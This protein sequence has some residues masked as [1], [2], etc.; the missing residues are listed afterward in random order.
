MRGRLHA[1][2][3]QHPATRSDRNRVA[4][5]SNGSNGSKSCST[6]QIN[7]S[8]PPRS[9][10]I[11]AESP[12]ALERPRSGPH[13][14]RPTPCSTGATRHVRHQRLRTP[15]ARL[16]LERARRATACRAAVSWASPSVS[17]RFAGSISAS[18]AVN[19]SNGPASSAGSRLRRQITT[20]TPR[21]RAATSGAGSLV[22]TASTPDR[23]SATA[24][25]GVVDDPCARRT[26]R[27]DAHAP[28][29]PGPPPSTSAD[30]RQH[31]RVTLLVARTPARRRPPPRGGQQPRRDPRFEFARPG[32]RERVEAG[33]QHRARRTPP[34][35]R[36]SSVGLDHPLTIG[37][38]VGIA[39]DV[40]DLDVD[41]DPTRHA[42]SA[43]RA[44]VGTPCEAT[45]GRRV[46]RSRRTS[47][48]DS[49]RTAPCPSVV[50]S[51]SA[52]CITTG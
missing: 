6:A 48:R 37:V 35:S 40:L 32:D 34:P 49:E 5:A 30:E 36:A 1:R 44:S 47:S 27:R 31:P 17:A 18:T 2:P 14:R 28:R 25:V 10:R 41:A 52:S 16:E 24:A 50:R 21:S 15:D 22:A 26:C 19:A 11:L 20:R 8:N 13:R 12:G 39:G 42:R 46:M 33:D 45:V 9:E 3:A 38:E 4:A 43:P 7:P 23:I 29:T 51:T